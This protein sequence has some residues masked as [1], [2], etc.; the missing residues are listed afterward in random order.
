MTI[1]ELNEIVEKLTERVV[2]LEGKA[3][4]SVAP[5]KSL[6]DQLTEKVVAELNEL[7]TN[8]KLDSTKVDYLKSLSLKVQTGEVKATEIDMKQIEKHYK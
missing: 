8:K 5:S 6:A 3:P 2:A 1:K 7:A 4:T